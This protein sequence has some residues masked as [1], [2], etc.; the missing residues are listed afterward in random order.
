MVRVSVG[1]RRVT[2]RLVTGRFLEGDHAIV[3][4][5]VGLFVLSSCL[6]SLRPFFFL[7]FLVSPAFSLLSHPPPPSHVPLPP[8]LVLF[9]SPPSP[10][11]CFVCC[12]GIMPVQ[13]RR[14]FDGGVSDARAR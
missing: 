14:R 11:H 2:C 1:P 7:F 5:L 3:L 13:S 10:R 6:L 9:L 8:F 4:V 12:G